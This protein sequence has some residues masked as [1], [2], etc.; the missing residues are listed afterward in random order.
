[1]CKKKNKLKAMEQFIKNGR[2][3]SALP[4]MDHLGPY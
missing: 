1:M 3:F 2:T 4:L